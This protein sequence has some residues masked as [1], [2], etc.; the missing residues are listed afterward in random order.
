MET[1]ANET[2]KTI[3]YEGRNEKSESM[4]HELNTSQRE[5][6]L[7][8][9]AMGKTWMQTCEGKGPAQRDKNSG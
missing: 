8:A 3:L 1:K 6:L 9:G 7:E 5:A 2:T 4:L